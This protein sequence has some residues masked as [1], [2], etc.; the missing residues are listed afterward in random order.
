ME[1]ER[2]SLT[3]EQ[4]E[5]FSNLLKDNEDILKQFLR[6]YKRHPEAW[7]VMSSEKKLQN[8]AA[9]LTVEDLENCFGKENI[10]EEVAKTFSSGT[11]PEKLSVLDSFSM[12]M[13]VALYK[14]KN[15]KTYRTR[16][17]AGEDVTRNLPTHVPTPTLTNYEYATSL[18]REGN[19]YLIQI[20]MSMDKLE[21]KNG[22]LYFKGDLK[23]AS[24]AELKKIA[25]IS[26]KKKDNNNTDESNSK[27]ES[28]NLPFLRFYYGMLTKEYE[29]SIEKNEDIPDVTTFYLPDL[30]E[31]RGLGRNINEKTIQAIIDDISGFHNI[32]GIMHINR[33]GRIDENIFPVLVFMGYD[34]GKNTISISSPYL[35]R[36]VKGLYHASIKKDKNGKQ[37]VSR[38]GI[39]QRIPINSYLVK[40]EILKERNKTAVENVFLIVTGIE[41][42]GGNG[43]NIAA[44]TLIER[45]PQLKERLK[46]SKN[47]SR[48]LRTCF[49]KTWELLSTMTDLKEKYKNIRL[50]NPNDPADI[51]TI[52]TLDKFVLVITHDGKIK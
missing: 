28:I 2:K 5:Q 1:R 32:A 39:V 22:K 42:A 46:S 51:P 10:S 21:Y 48:V 23:V 29:I 4:Q 47:P 43:Y 11:D 35:L 37:K 44:K 13:I 40:S 12:N 45:N 30:A 6:D 17:K 36:I 27:I 49:K 7:D 38:G 3:Q 26:K 9:T 25:E 31:A 16:S 34:A 41:K 8:F 52:G 15:P 18:N 50:P 33:N 19:A 24:E 14:Y 20:M